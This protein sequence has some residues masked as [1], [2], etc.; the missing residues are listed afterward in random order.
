MMAV[1]RKIFWGFMVF[2][3]AACASTTQDMYRDPNMDFGAVR[4]IAVLPFVNLSRDQ[5]AGDRVRDVFVSALLAT[6]AIY[7]LPPGEVARGVAAMEI[8]NP[9]TPSPAEIV[10]LGKAIKAEAVITGTLRE[11]G[12]VRSGSASANAISLSLQVIET[13]TGRVVWSAATTKGGIS[14]SDRLFGGGGQPM[15]VV[16]VQAVNDIINKLFR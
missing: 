5:L 2:S 7:V 14:F 13:E 6:G 8:Q 16:T 1:F 9:V 12:D 4:T 10:K 11:Y 15:D 3:L